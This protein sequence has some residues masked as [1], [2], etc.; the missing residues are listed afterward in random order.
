MEF[1]GYHI[2]K[3]KVPF[4][5]FS[6]IKSSDI[7]QNNILKLPKHLKQK[8]LQESRRC[9]NIAGIKIS[10][11]NSENTWWTHLYSYD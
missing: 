7:N 2:L 6:K 8:R 1:V 5:N 10:P 9:P 3:V 11:H 4:P